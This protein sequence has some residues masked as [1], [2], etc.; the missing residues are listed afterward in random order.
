MFLLL[1]PVS[2]ILHCNLNAGWRPPFSL[3]LKVA[4][5]LY[6]WKSQYLPETGIHLIVSAGWEMCLTQYLKE[7]KSCCKCN[8]AKTWWP[9]FPP[10]HHVH[11]AL[12]GYSPWGREIC[13]IPSLPLSQLQSHAVTCSNN[14]RGG[15]L[16]CLPIKCVFEERKDLVVSATS[17]PLTRSS[18]P[19]CPTAW[20]TTDWSNRGSA[21]TW[22]PTSENEFNIICGGL[23]CS[24]CLFSPRPWGL[25]L[26]FHLQKCVFSR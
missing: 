21:Q 18:T 9:V 4:W 11:R 12:T 19:L 16:P 25:L 23:F 8:T 24:V 14:I 26:P 5:R 20:S 1:S 22:P 7:K 6:W 17:K 10:L 13:H 3:V 15:G 2:E